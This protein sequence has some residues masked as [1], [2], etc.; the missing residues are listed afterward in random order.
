MNSEIEMKT[1]D[2]V[3]GV[4]E[5]N[6]GRCVSGEYIA[7]ELGISR[8]AVWKFVNELR[9]EGYRIDA[10]TNRGY[11]LSED[12]DILSAQGIYPFLSED[13]RRFSENILV[14]KTLEST[15]LKAKELALGG[16]ADGTTV[17]SD[18]QSAGR[19]RFSREFFSPA[20]KGLYM[21]VIRRGIPQVFKA[22]AAVTA[23]AAVAVCNAIERVSNHTCGIKWVN[24][25]Y[26]NQKKVC[27]ILTE[28][29]Y[30]L[31]SGNF[32]WFVIGIGINVSIGERE[33]PEDIRG[34]AV[35]LFPEGPPQ[36]AR[37]R[38]CAEILNEILKK[39]PPSSDALFDSYKKRLTVLGKNVTVVENGGKE[40]YSAKVIDVDR[41][42]R[43]VVVGEDGARRALLPGEARIS[44]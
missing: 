4:L 38:L 1:K 29:S 8:N 6:R 40:S 2:R 21:S 31:E 42:G 37:N 24:D 11:S 32:D 33:F 13:A 19:G 14:F 27:G 36:A 12:G 43:L 15:N 3:L 44:F 34:F 18:A 10:A 28:A 7:E 5:M 39:N 20:G 30:D 25:I 26:I 9:R 17:I 41:G 23:H 16:A 35:S 22:P